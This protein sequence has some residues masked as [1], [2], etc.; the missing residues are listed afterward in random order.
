MRLDRRYRLAHRMAE[1]LFFRFPFPGS[2]KLAR[3]LA[4]LL[5]P[6]PHSPVAVP[7]VFDFSLLIHPR[8]HTDV[9][10]L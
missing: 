6:R 10:Y 2:R 9:Y 7:T 3:V 8:W 4:H 1:A 5:L